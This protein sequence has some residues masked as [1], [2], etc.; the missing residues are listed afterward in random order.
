MM[1]RPYS[2]YAIALAAFSLHLVKTMTNYYPY[3]DAPYEMKLKMIAEGQRLDRH[4]YE[5]SR[6]GMTQLS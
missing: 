6:L 5:V 1:V 2:I 4:Y 3:K